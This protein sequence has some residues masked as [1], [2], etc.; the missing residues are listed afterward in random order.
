LAQGKLSSRA[1]AS[2]SSLTWPAVM[3][4]LIGC[5]FASV[6]AC[7]LVFR[8]S[9]VRPISRLKMS[10]PSLGMNHHHTVLIVG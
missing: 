1:A 2:V 10:I 3:S 6:T 9:L 5:P 4:G 8:L 7:S